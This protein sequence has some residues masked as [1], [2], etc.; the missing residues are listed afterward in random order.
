MM[1]ILNTYLIDHFVEICKLTETILER[2]LEIQDLR[3]YENGG[4]CIR[5]DRDDSMLAIYGHVRSITTMEIA[6][7]KKRGIFDRNA[8][9]ELVLF[10]CLRQG[11]LSR[12]QV[13]D[14]VGHYIWTTQPIIP[15][16]LRAKGEKS[17]V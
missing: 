6:K 11:K 9:I 14:R 3:K 17:V 1:S 15:S 4:F 13:L 10:T 2:P 8:S 7:D 16:K 5:H 12:I